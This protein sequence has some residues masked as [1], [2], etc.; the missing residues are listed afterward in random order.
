MPN[1][2]IYMYNIDMILIFLKVEWLTKSF[3]KFLRQKLDAE[4]LFVS[5]RQTLTPGVLDN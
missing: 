2:Y 4:A 5:N 3:Y 1:R